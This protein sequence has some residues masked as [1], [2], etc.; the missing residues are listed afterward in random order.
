MNKTYQFKTYDNK[1]IEIR[2]I[3]FIKYI[4]IL[5]FLNKYRISNFLFGKFFLKK[6]INKI[7][8][9]Q[10]NKKMIW[11]NIFWDNINIKLIETKVVLDSDLSIIANNYKLYSNK[12]RFKN[13][14]KY[15]FLLKSGHDMGAPL[16]I[17]ASCINYL[18]GSVNNND[19][20]M[21]DGSRRLYAHILNESNPDIL[22]IDIK[23]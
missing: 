21:L 17:S 6:L 2:F 5:V 14:K 12:K 19:I 1:K 20:F 15:Q 11:K 9:Y 10:L 23:K 16:F 4:D 8:K 3:A 18:G 13:I 7:F 22:F